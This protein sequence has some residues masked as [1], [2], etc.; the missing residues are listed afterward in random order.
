MAQEIQFDAINTRLDRLSRRLVDLERK[1]EFLL[2][3]EPTKYV[4]VSEDQITGMEKQVADLL[5]QGKTLEAIKAYRKVFDVE[6]EL[7]KERVE[8]IRDRIGTGS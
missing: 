5:K 8:E 4:P 3:H 1:V 6:M 7:A 2:N